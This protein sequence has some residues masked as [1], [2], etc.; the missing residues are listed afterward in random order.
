MNMTSA[1]HDVLTRTGRR[2]ARPIVLAPKLDGAAVVPVEEEEARQTRNFVAG[3]LLFV[4]SV[5][6]GALLMNWATTYQGHR[7]A[8]TPWSITFV[9]VVGSFCVA[10]L[11]STL[12]RHRRARA[13]DGA[14]PSSA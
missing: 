13:D 2:E 14:P 5:T 9:A 11:A 7:A 8:V 12:L 6:I 1:L 3:S 4:V 10:E